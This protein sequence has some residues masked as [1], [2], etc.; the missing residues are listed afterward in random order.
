MLSP[1]V[2]SGIWMRINVA[3]T[4]GTGRFGGGIHSIE[5]LLLINSVVRRKL[6]LYGSGIYKDDEATSVNSIVR[7]STAGTGGGANNVVR[8]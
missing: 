8:P 4:T 5:T 2:G 3:G 1:A 7:G 6:D